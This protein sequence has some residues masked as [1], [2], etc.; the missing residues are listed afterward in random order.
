MGPQNVCVSQGRGKV[1][2]IR[3]AGGREGLP[4]EQTGVPGLEA[5]LSNAER[6]ACTDPEAAVTG[7]WRSIAGSKERTPE[8]RGAA[9]G[10]AQN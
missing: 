6:T 4:E 9:G 10:G 3:R 5:G 7:C 8:G 1:T 2:Q